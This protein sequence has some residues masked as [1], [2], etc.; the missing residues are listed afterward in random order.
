MSNKSALSSREIICF[1]KHFLD[2]GM[3][4][5]LITF[6]VYRLSTSNPRSDCANVVG[7]HPHT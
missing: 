6:G 5:L 3:L 2:T 7:S 1:F 4:K